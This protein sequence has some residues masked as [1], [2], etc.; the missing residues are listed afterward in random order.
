MK[1]KH[2]IKAI[3]L[4]ALMI[5]FTFSTKKQ[6]FADNDVMIPLQKFE[7]I[8]NIP[9]PSLTF[10]NLFSNKYRSYSEF[11]I[12]SIGQV[13]VMM[14]TGLGVTGQGSVWIS[15]DR[16][17][18]DIIGEVIE[19]KPRT[20]DYSWFLESGT[21]YINFNWDYGTVDIRAALL[22]ERATTE[23]ILALSSLRNTNPIELETPAKGFVS[24]LT[25]NDF[26]SFVLKEKANVSIEYL[27]D[28]ANNTDDVVGRC[29]LYDSNRVFLTD[30]EYKSTDRGQQSIVYLLEP[31]SYY[32]RLNGMYG[33]TLLNVKP[34]YYDI[35]L[36]PEEI[37]GWTDEPY[38][39]DIVTAIE[40]SE[41]RV[42]FQDVKEEVINDATVWNDQNPLNVKVDGL[43]FEVAK[44]GVYS[45]RITDQYGNRTMEKIEIENIDVTKPKITGVTNNKSYKKAVTIKFTDKQSGIDPVK[46]TLNGKPVTSGTKLEEEGKYTL[47]VYDEM[48]NMRKRIFYID[49]TAPT[50]GVTNKKTYTSSVTLRFYDKLSGL[51]KITVNN[52][53]LDVKV[54]TRRY[55]M[56]GE[57][58]VK[59]WDNA[60]NYKK[61]VFYIK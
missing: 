24:N 34:M 37:V 20:S 35:E 33:D 27:F 54:K 36:L 51:K 40:Y 3:L 52:E 30:G 26:Y 25:P 43:T 5:G 42:L 12:D 4:F 22:F 41:I 58:V 10:F 44:S 18:M 21:Y 49:Y 50:S 56:E 7:E 11:T 39:V 31:G 57:Y 59:L 1:Q 53:E 8:D 47:K 48:G 38:D 61:E 9:Y 28:A 13:K 32:I 19:V 29:T 16:L 6:V 46:T 55:F 15:R 2:L 60:G 23:E 45:A 17:G 14:Q